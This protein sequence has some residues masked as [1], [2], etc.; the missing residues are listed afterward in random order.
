MKAVHD[1]SQRLGNLEAKV[2]AISATL[3]QLVDK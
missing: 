3:Q 2:E 1:E